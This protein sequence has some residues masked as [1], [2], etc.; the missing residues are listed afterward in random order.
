MEA[1]SL[2]APLRPDGLSSKLH[3]PGKFIIPSARHSERRNGVYLVNKTFMLE[4]SQTC[5][6]ILHASIH[7]DKKRFESKRAVCAASQCSIQQNDK[8]SGVVSQTQEFKNKFSYSFWSQADGPVKVSVVETE[9]KFV[10]Y[11]QVS[12]LCRALSD[13]E[14]I[15]SIFRSDSSSLIA[16]GSKKFAAFT[17]NPFTEA[18]TESSNFISMSFDQRYLDGHVVSLEFPSAQAPFFVSF[19]L[20]TSPDSFGSGGS[21]FGTHK[22]TDFCIPVGIGRGHPMPLGVSFSTDE[23]VNFSIFSKNAES[24]ILCLYTGVSNDCTLEI[25]LDPFVNR[26]GDVWH[27]KMNNCQNYV[28]YGYRCKGDILWD[29]GC[30]F[31][32]RYVLLDPYTKILGKFFPSK[33]QEQERLASQTKYLGLLQKMPFFD[34]SSDVHPHIPMEK[35]VVY[36]LNVGLFTEDTSSQLSA[37]LMGTFAGLEKKIHHFKN[38]GVNA[39]LSHP[40]FSFDETKGPY[41]PYNFF[42]PMNNYGPEKDGVSAITSMK[43]MVKSLHAQGIELLLE[44]V[45]SHT[46]EGGDAACQMITF[47]GIDNSVYYNVE[48]DIGRETYNSINC[49]NPIVQG[50][51]LESLRYWVSEFHIDGFCFVNTSALVQGPDNHSLWQSP[52]IEAIAGD[53]L[54]SKTKIVADFWSPV[55]MSYKKVKF[56]HWKRFAEMNLQFC[57]DVRNFLKGEGLLCDIATRVCGSG[58]IFSDGRGP[59]FAFNFIS[60]NLSLIDLV[61]YNDCSEQSWN[62]GEEGPT[63]NRGVVE[64]RHRQI[65]NFLFILFVSLGVPVINMGDECGFSTSNDK[66]RAF[67]WTCLNSS[68]GTENVAFIA[69]LSSLRSRRNDLLQ[70]R[71]FLKVE[72]IEWHGSDQSYLDWND[73]ASCKFLGMLLK[74][75]WADISLSSW[76]KGNMFAVFNSSGFPLIA[77]LPQ[78]PWGSFWVR[79][80]DTSLPFPVFFANYDD[81]D[82][83]SCGGL[84]SYQLQPHSCALF[85][86]KKGSIGK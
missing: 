85:E 74:P 19:N 4:R 45:F 35:M 84:N 34:W 71:N 64:L 16:Q 50:M 8:V 79:L 22:N 5:A 59:S 51:I 2:L 41:F 3:G 40:I 68:F 9:A 20:H 25:A 73:P 21:V 54:L 10:V 47:R 61:S 48:G 65:R 66:Q 23:S 17:N 63:T 77:T 80:V 56:R 72:N 13:L 36:R 78:L 26:T 57:F 42:S 33:V 52:L 75:N 38:L 28:A 18:V 32:M 62:C 70:A 7:N 37:N 43:N 49:N 76:D 39:I 60:K 15:W 67:D 53:P 27:V 12:S 69:F 58:D 11:I 86:A 55:D 14:L 83:F 31:H 81:P 82:A 29:T 46:A 30:R 44:V 6:N 1:L 24:V